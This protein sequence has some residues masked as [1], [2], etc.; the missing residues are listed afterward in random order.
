MMHAVRKK[1]LLFPLKIGLDRMSQLF[2][3]QCF[4]FFNDSCQVGRTG[5]LIALV[6][7][8][9]GIVELFCADNLHH[10]MLE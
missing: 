9:T 7:S 3:A 6:L 10:F 4:I 1:K 5:P 8:G 2:M